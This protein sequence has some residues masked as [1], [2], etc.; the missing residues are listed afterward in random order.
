MSA[1]PLFLGL[2]LSTQQLKLSLIDSSR[3]LV[4]DAAIHFDHDLPKYGTKD[5]SIHRKGGV[6]VCPTACWV[7]AV[8]MCFER[9][10]EKMGKD[11]VGRI[12]GIGGAAQQHGSVYLTSSFL[13]TLSSLSP[14]SSLTSQLSPPLVYSRTES[15]IWQDSSTTKEC[16]ELER[17]VGGAQALSDK[18]GS[19]AYERFTGT[20]I[21][22]VR[23]LEWLSLN[24]T[25]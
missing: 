17:A 10:S 16:R 13:P 12:R 11:V 23:S 18:T 5:G 6:A 22:K 9:M 24:Q 19:R 25:C 7:E 4:Y 3:E 21:R 15:P 14:S 8:D 2:D 20:Q 1:S